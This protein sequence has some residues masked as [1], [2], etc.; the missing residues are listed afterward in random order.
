MTA[1]GIWRSR[2]MQTSERTRSYVGTTRVSRQDTKSLR[3]RMI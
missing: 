3:V 2:G 1:L